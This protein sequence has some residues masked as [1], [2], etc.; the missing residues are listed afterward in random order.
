M[1]LFRISLVQCQIRSTASV[2]LFDLPAAT[3]V[4]CRYSVVSNQNWLL[5]SLLD[6][7]QGTGKKEK[8]ATQSLEF[9]LEFS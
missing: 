5:W 1:F 4:E 9:S 2:N 7:K 3:S 6:T 8:L